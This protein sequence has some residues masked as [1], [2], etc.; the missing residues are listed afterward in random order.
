MDFDQTQLPILI[1]TSIT[2]IKAQARK[3]GLAW[4]CTYFFTTAYLFLPHGTH[5][6]ISWPQPPSWEPL[7][8]GIQIVIFIVVYRL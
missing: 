2:Q 1:D 4:G 7:Y 5:Q 3:R 8:L 6:M